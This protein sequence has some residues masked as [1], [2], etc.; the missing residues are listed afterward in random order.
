MVS[1]WTMT[2]VTKEEERDKEFAVPIFLHLQLL[3][4][5]VSHSWQNLIP[6]GINHTSQWQLLTISRLLTPFMYRDNIL[7]TTGTFQERI[8]DW[9][10]VSF[11][12]GSSRPREQTLNSCVSWIGCC[13]P[14]VTQSYL[15]LCN[16]MN[17]STPGF[18]VLHY[19]LELTQIHAHW[20]CHPIISFSLVPSP[21]AFNLSQHQSLYQWAGSLHQVAKVLKLQFQHQ[22]F[23]WIF[24]VNFL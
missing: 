15:T 4:F 23:Q 5:G 24:R 2:E 9:A 17:C 1:L 8:L 19:L 16:F 3:I 21:S 14:S 20:W 22:S 7:S 6:I 13:G 18:P 10:A 11:S 12:R